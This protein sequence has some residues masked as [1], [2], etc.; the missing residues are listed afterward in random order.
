MHHLLT[1]RDPQLEP[2]F[3]F[4]RVRELAPEVS[5]QT[6]Q[7][8]MWTFKRDSGEAPGFGGGDARRAAGF[9]RRR[10]AVDFAPPA[11]PPPLSTMQ[12][13]VLTKP[14]PVAVEENVTASRTAAGQPARVNRGAGGFANSQAGRSE[15]QT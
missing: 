9:K 1:G 11:V 10:V 8:V 2:P 13:Q 14:A 6:E 5:P 7:V 12:T 3:S 4:P 15:G